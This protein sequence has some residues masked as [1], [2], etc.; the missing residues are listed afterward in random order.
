MPLY[1]LIKSHV[2]SGR[3]HSQQRT[4][5][6]VC[7]KVKTR[8]GRIWTYRTS[9]SPFGGKAPPR[10]MFFYFTGSR[11]HPS[12]SS[13]SQDIPG[14]FRPMLMPGSMRSTRRNRKPGPITEAGC[15][16]HART[17]AVRACRHRFEG[18]QPRSQFADRFQAD[19]SS[20]PSSCWSAQSTA[21]RPEQR[22]AARCKDIAPLVNDLIEWMKRERAKL[23]RHNEV[24][25]ATDYMLKR[26]DIFTRF[27]EDGRHLPE[28]QC[29][30]ARAARGCPWPEV[31]VV[32]RLRPRRRARRGHADADFKL[33]SSVRS[34]RKLG[35]PM[36]SPGS[37]IT[38]SPIWPHCYPGIGAPRSRSPAP[39]D[40]AAPASA[41]T[42]SRAAEILGE[43]EGLL[44][45]MVDEMEPERR[46]PLDLWH[47]RS[48]LSPSRPP[49]WNICGSCSPSTNVIG[50]PRRS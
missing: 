36:R 8:T 16:A 25:K 39:P 7:A 45:E 15:W 31:L 22:V 17:Q 38:R 33:P 24:A 18:A 41:V 46:L 20:T 23:S 10:S 6:R 1:E 35:S 50:H 32:R 9:P 4:H 27:L 49:G 11:R 19:S 2:F 28:Q 14:S 3:T 34:I 43:D 44:W 37:P 42:I 30:R 47:G 26:I 29:S 5:I 12:P 13:I 40:M 21:C 48:R